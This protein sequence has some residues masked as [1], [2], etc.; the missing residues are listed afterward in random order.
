MAQ[1]KNPDRHRLPGVL[2]R[3]DPETREAIRQALEARGW[4]LNEFLIA[5]M[6]LGAANPDA[7]LQRL[8]Q[9]RPDIRNGRPARQ[10]P[11]T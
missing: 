5:C 2:A 3:P 10:D 7:M 1:P 9:F 8:R 4:S 11:S 6:K